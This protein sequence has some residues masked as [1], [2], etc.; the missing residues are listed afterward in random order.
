MHLVR[1]LRRRATARGDN[2]VIKS[3]KLCREPRD[4]RGP[5]ETGCL[6]VS[7]DSHEAKYT[8]VGTDARCTLVAA[9]IT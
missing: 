7:L 1:D 4:V 3:F 2:P 6:S 5:N 8:R 9:K